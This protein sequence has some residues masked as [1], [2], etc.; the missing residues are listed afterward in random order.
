MPRKAWVSTLGDTSKE[1]YLQLARSYWTGNEDAENGDPP[2]V[3]QQL[4]SV[5]GLQR[6][7]AKRL[8]FFHDLTP[9]K[10]QRA[11]QCEADLISHPVKDPIALSRHKRWTPFRITYG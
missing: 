1:G 6:A 9:W 5:A 8:F 4:D 7:T 3:A 10:L 11:R 2:F